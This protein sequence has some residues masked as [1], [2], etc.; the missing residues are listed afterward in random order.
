M[1]GA[2]SGSGKGIS[3][4]AGVEEIRDKEIGDE[5]VSGKMFI[6]LNLN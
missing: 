2:G 4:E 6:P 3:V 5:R 1:P